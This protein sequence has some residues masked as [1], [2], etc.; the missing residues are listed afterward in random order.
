MSEN[1]CR[2]GGLASKFLRK[3]IPGRAGLVVLRDIKK[4]ANAFWGLLVGW[5]WS[6]IFSDGRYDN[7]N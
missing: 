2:A 5:F 6:K 3:N 1:A 4:P 7:H